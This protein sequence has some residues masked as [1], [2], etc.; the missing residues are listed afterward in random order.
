[1]RISAVLN[2][3]P[4]ALQLRFGSTWG[5]IHGGASLMNSS[6]PHVY[7]LEFDGSDEYVSEVWMSYASWDAGSR[8]AGALLFVTNLGRT[9]GLG[10]R[11]PQ[12]GQE[13]AASPAMPCSESN[14]R[15]AYVDTNSDGA[16]YIYGLSLYW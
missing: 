1:M 3:M 9:V 13:G 7:E 6:L 16:S 2:S 10:S 12:A 5:P 14:H 8:Y 11:E 4:Y 15:L